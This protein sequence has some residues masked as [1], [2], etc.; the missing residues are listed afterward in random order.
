[1]V[2]EIKHYILSTATVG[3]V[4]SFL[5]WSPLL[6][7]EEFWVLLAGYVK[8]GV[9]VML[10]IMNHN[11]E[12][13]S[14][15]SAH[16][17]ALYWQMCYGWNIFFEENV[18]ELL[19][20]HKTSKWLPTIH[21]YTASKTSLWVYHHEINCY[22][23][24]RKLLATTSNIPREPEILLNIQDFSSIRLRTQGMTCPQRCFEQSI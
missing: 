7:R 6:P 5:P 11:Q 21:S 16:S 3:W 19:L 8:Y 14:G 10:D 9:R 24:I 15:H 23:S 17:L 4:P 22:I 12:S 20:L 1:M 13:N 2:P 18:T